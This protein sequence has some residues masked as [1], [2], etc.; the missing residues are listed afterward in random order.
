MNWKRPRGE[1]KSKGKV[2]EKR[3]YTEQFIQETNHP[4]CLAL[5]CLAVPC[6]AVLINADESSSSSS[7]TFRWE[8]AAPWYVCLCCLSLRRHPLQGNVR[9][10][11]SIG[12]GGGGGGD[13]ARKQGKENWDG[14]SSPPS[15]KKKDHPNSNSAGRKTKRNRETLP[16]RHP[17]PIHPSWD[18][19]IFPSFLPSFLPSR[20]S[21]PPNP[22]IHRPNVN[23]NER[24]K[25]STKITKP[26][27]HPILS[28]LNRPSVLDP[29]P[30][31]P[32]RNEAQM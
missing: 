6:R 31:S 11:G 22:S 7:Q 17:S 14:P 24:K 16:A 21:C 5:P 32:L 29:D 23:E 18:C 28:R 19:L 2:V 26:S 10:V 12:G 30:G 4:P 3:D 8:Q 27:T 1:I 9:V 15:E 20:S 25:K 13:K